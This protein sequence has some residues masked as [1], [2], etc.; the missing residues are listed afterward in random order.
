MRKILCTDYSSRI[1]TKLNCN[2][3]NF[4]LFSIL[5]HLPSSSFILYSCVLTAF[6]IKRISVNQSIN[7]SLYP[8]RTC[9]IY[10]ICA[11]FLKVSRLIFLGLS[12][13]LKAILHQL[14]VEILLACYLQWL[15]WR[16]FRRAER[17]PYLL[18]PTSMSSRSTSSQL[19]V[20]NSMQCTPECSKNTAF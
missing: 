2:E 20:Q 13:L 8:W 6:N 5:S 14:S 11:I 18:A 10:R 4:I 19:S 7:Q 16:W 12:H 15:K 3:P 17:P 1:C 9:C